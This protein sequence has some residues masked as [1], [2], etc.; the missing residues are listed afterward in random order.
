MRATPEDFE[1]EEIAGFEPSGSG[2]HAL[3]WVEKRGANT[4]H[5]ARELARF[6]GVSELAVGFAGMKDRHA[7][8]RQRF[9]VHLPGRPEPD[10]AALAQA[11]F[12]VLSATRHA[13]KLPR[14]ALAGNRFG[15]TL[16]EV[17]GERDAAEQILGRI[18]ARGV[19]N[20]FGEQRFGRAGDNVAQARAMFAGARVRRA[21]RSLLLSAARSEI[22]N[23][24]L[25]E[26][27]AQQTWERTLE[28]DVYQLD[29]RGSIFGPEP[30]SPELEQRIADAA[31]HPTG[32][33]WGRGE[34][35]T[36]GAAQQQGVAQRFPELCAGLEAA[37]LKQERRALRLRIGDFNWAWIEPTALRLELVLGPG[38]YAT[39][40]LRELSTSDFV[41]PGENAQ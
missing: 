41:T 34:L 17:S 32:P 4:T 27:V 7:V 37:G 35:R 33:L 36:T 38:C 14:G 15:I 26:R 2:E 1:V 10:W 25:A 3:L 39:T 24:I 22:F 31:V 23:R 29:G 30:A 11:E 40:V 6:A 5:V 16:R 12:R 13:R 19:P 28:G 18:A 21:E 8:T 9:S 20:Y